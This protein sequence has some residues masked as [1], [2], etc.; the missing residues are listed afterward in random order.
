MLSGLK[1]LLYEGS[2]APCSEDELLVFGE[3][4]FEEDT[5]DWTISLIFLRKIETSL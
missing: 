4:N 1:I 5:Y 3:L 2:Y